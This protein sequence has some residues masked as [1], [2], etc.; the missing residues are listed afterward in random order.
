MKGRFIVIEGIDG[1][2]KTTLAHSLARMIGH[3]ETTFEPTD[4]PIGSVLRS[5]SLGDIPPEAEA[6]LFAADR[7][8]HTEAMRKVLDS[9]RWVIC[10][11]YTGST[12][13]YQAA[14]LGDRADRDWL[15][16]IQKRSVMRPDLS[17]LLDI[18]PAVSM[19]RVG[20]RG[21]E[22]SRF[23]RLDFLEKVRSEYLRLAE[24][25]GYEVVDASRPPE[26]ILGDV[27]DIMEKKGLY[28]SERRDLL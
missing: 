1:S 2:G 24:V 14:S 18:D 4:G 7:T 23:E 5:G 12:V 26:E 19:A 20:S 9:G 15:L 27:L 28:A 22:L 10:D 11:R 8:I 3:A 21:E 16:D 6:L 13:A 17:V 25:L